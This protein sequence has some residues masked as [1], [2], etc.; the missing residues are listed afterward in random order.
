[1]ISLCRR[2]GRHP[3]CLT[4]RGVEKLGQY[5]VGGGAFGDVWR[6]KVGEQLVCLKVIRAFETSDVQQILKDYMQEAVIWRQLN[7]QNVLPFMG[8][9]YLDS[10]QKQ[11]ALVSPWMERGN[12][13][14]Y[15]KNTPV[16][17]VDHD[18]LAHD[19]ACGLCYLHQANIVHA[20]LKGLNV[21][22]TPDL[23]ACLADFGLA[24][25]SATQLLLTETSRSKGTTRWLSPELLNPG[26]SCHPSKESDI[27]AYACVCYEIYTGHA[28]FYEMSEATIVLAIVINKKRPSR[29]EN[30]IKL[31]DSIWDMMVEC[32]NEVP[33]SRP[34]IPKI[35][36]RILEMKGSRRL[37]QPSQWKNPAFT[38]IWNDP[39]RPPVV[40][41]V[42][43]MLPPDHR[44]HSSQTSD[45][46]SFVP[47]PPKQKFLRP[48][49]LEQIRPVAALKRKGAS[50]E[51]DDGDTASLPQVKRQH[52]SPLDQ[53]SRWNWSSP[54]PQ[55]FPPWNI[56]PPPQDLQLNFM[57]ATPMLKPSPNPGSGSTQQPGTPSSG[58]A[59]TSQYTTQSKSGGALE[60]P[61][62]DTAPMWWDCPSPPGVSNDISPSTPPFP[63]RRGGMNT[64][65]SFR[66]ASNGGAP[67]TSSFLSPDNGPALRSKRYG[68]GRAP[69]LVRHSL[70]EDHRFGI[71]GVNVSDRQD[72]TSGE[73]LSFP[74][75]SH[76][77]FVRQQQ[78]R[79]PR[80]GELSPPST[81]FGSYQRSHS[82]SGGGPLLPSQ[83][84]P[85]PNMLFSGGPMPGYNSG[86]GHGPGP[87]GGVPTGPIEPNGAPL[88]SAV[89][90]GG[91]TVPLAVTKMTVTNGRTARVSHN[92]RKQEATFHCPVPGCGSTFTRSFN[93][94]GH[95]RS[96]NEE[97]PFVTERNAGSSSM[98]MS[99]LSQ[100]VPPVPS[101]SA[102]SQR[103]QHQTPNAEGVGGGP[104]GMQRGIGGLPN[105][106]S[107]LPGTPLYNL[108]RPSQ[109][110]QQPVETMYSVASQLEDS[111]LF[112]P[113]GVSSFERD[114]EKWFNLDTMDTL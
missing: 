81:D 27:Y 98:S 62:W 54:P 77:D 5:P 16:K 80:Y 65:F 48:E 68:Y 50:E 12:L 2:S 39:Q 59:L 29:P 75:T 78:L 101:L 8:A 10:E 45:L 1:M 47:D 15:L 88:Q 64:Q 63:Q 100:P 23:R 46:D 96:H 85:P 61:P 110:Q 91:T 74:S 51:D 83:G 9:Y 99:L 43:P 42:Q 94:K 70:S 57:V 106:L 93:L 17:D 113:G 108:R 36:T 52:L 86:M 69:D 25:V 67:A 73:N 33:S 13:V 111:G 40:H 87:M 105:S 18:L 22:I 7:H 71:P 32:W 19:V 49:E 82:D 76:V 55:V 90:V 56:S 38:H 97:R 107:G 4:I 72:T 14:Q 58:P 112:G 89:T 24:R 109:P 6:G 114:F 3:Q 66:G 104:G 34:T 30:C 84:L 20:D 26:P 21:L 41:A 44:T 103:S 60:S 53:Q 95:L 31:H 102:Q 28:P 92:R 11:L 37:E 35:L 79:S